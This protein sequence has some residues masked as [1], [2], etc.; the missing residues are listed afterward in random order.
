MSQKQIPSD[1]QATPRLLADRRILVTGAGDGIGRAVS[2]ALAGH[3]ATVIL[4]GRT[5]HKLE[6]VYDQIIDAG[7]P[8]PAL[9]PLNLAGAAPDDY[10]QLA[11]RV[12]AELGGLEGLVHNAG[13]LGSLS[14]LLHYD[15]TEW[16]EVM[17]VN[18]NG[19]FFLTRACLPLLERAADASILFTSS[20]VGFHGRAYWGA[21]AVSKFASE[22]LMQ[23]LAEEVEASGTLRVNS[24]NPGRV[25]TNM[26]AAAYPAEDPQSLLAPEEIV[27]PYLYLL[28][29]DS[30]GINGQAYSFS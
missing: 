4:L 28:G 22:G 9:Y 25:R 19:A 29:P 30:R 7:G 18:V 20:N 5:V 3:G 13:I 12:E 10:Q 21:Y 11:T 16:M 1:Y 15:E 23:V 17:Q 27:M 6:A 26:R 24:F 8:Q 2:L 14:P